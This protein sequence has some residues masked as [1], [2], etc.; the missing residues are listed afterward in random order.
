MQV[1]QEITDWVYPNHIYHVNDGGDLVAYKVADKGL[2]T[3]KEPLK[4]NKSKRKFKVLET[5][6]EVNPDA[7]TVTGSNGKVYTIIDGKCSCPGFS[8]RGKCK[9]VD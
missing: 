6:A 3:F 8:F 5:I 9:H 1:L 4:F 2:V 7:I